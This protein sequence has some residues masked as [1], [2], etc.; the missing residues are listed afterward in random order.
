MNRMISP[1]R[2]DRCRHR[3]SFRILVTVL[4]VVTNLRPRCPWRGSSRR[5][6]EEA[7][8]RLIG[9]GNVDQIDTGIQALGVLHDPGFNLRRGLRPQKQFDSARGVATVVFERNRNR[10]VSLLR[11]GDVCV[12]K[13]IH[14]LLQESAKGRVAEVPSVVCIEVAIL[15]R[16]ILAV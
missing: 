3:D 1:S 11:L 10:N 9:G 7:R 4:Q 5:G 2:G 15:D 14:I 8:I 6:V 13:Q 12:P 16:K